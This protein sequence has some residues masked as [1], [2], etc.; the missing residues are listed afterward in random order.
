MILSASRG[1][2][3]T[4]AFNFK[5]PQGKSVGVP[6][7]EYVLTLERGSFVREFRNLRR[8]SGAVIWDMTAE[9]TGAL[10]YENMYFVLSWND[11]E[12]ARGVLRVH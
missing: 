11:T 12:L 7:G 5:S 1:K 2:P 6:A 4:E 3:F 8:G 9:D 10:E